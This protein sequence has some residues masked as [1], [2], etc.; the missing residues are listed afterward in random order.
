MR[1]PHWAIEQ[2]ERGNL[3][4]G[5]KF[6][7]LTQAITKKNAQRFVASLSRKH[8]R[9]VKAYIDGCPGTD[10]GWSN[11][12]FYR[13]VSCVRR[14]SAEEAEAERAEEIRLHRRGV[15]IL[16]DVIGPQVVVEPYVLAW[17]GGTIPKL[18][19]A[20]HDERRW[21]DMVILADA[22]EEAGCNDEELLNHCRKQGM[23]HVRGCWAIRALL[24]VKP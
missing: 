2:Y 3:T 9:E 13:I 20:I 21:E 7:L 1:T 14:V 18:A 23:V 11:L 6:L 12:R 15:E 5:E 17:K 4:E 19:R 8:L 24:R 22:L 10:E 16:R